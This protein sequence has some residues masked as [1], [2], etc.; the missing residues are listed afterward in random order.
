MVPRIRP[1]GK[2]P[3]GD[4]QIPWSKRL[5]ARGRTLPFSMN[6]APMIDVTFLLLIFF[7]VTTTFE[8]AEGLLASQLPQDRGRPAVALPVSPIVIQLDQIGPGEEDYQISLRNVQRIPV[9]FEELA[10]ILRMILDRPGFDTETPVVIQA[11]ERVRW[12]HVVNAWNA[13][14][15]CEFANIAF[16]R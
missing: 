4:E 12:D 13:A 3:D 14:V 6:I 10:D 2:A 15:R 11:G 7:L 9:S 8:K 16:G 1:A 5:H